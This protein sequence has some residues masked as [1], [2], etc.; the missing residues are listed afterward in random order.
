MPRDSGFHPFK[1]RV[2]RHF[3]DSVCSSLMLKRPEQRRQDKSDASSGVD[4]ALVGHVWESE[5]MAN[6][7]IGWTVGA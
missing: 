5:E 1:G 2:S 4:A 6:E 3:G 7:E